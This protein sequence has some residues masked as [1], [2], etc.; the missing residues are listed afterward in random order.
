M[1]KAEGEFARCNYSLCKMS[2]HRSMKA[3]NGRMKK[4]IAWGSAY[5]CIPLFVAQR[6]LKV[7]VMI[8]KKMLTT[9]NP[10]P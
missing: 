7:V 8:Q 2:V 6:R 1:L 10:S 3:H 5:G 4:K 9:F